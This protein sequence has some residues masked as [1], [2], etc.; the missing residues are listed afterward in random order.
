MAGHHQRLGACS[1]SK[2]VTGTAKDEDGDIIG[3]CGGWGFVTKATARDLIDADA[4]A[5]H[6]NGS[7]VTVVESEEVEDGFYLR[8]APGGGEDDN[9]DNLPDC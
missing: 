3:L 4:T 5:F 6:V 8:T 2:E 1:L 7:L 9:L